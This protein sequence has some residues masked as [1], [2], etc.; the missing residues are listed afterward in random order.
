MTK[1]NETMPK[2]ETVFVAECLGMKANIGIKP[3]L[4]PKPIPLQ[5]SEVSL[6]EKRGIENPPKPILP[7]K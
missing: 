7:E 3:T 5:T 2:Q 6:D 4:P 1:K